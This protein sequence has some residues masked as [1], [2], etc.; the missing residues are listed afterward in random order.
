M[1]EGWQEF[2][3]GNKIQFEQEYEVW[4]DELLTLLR[5]SQNKD[6]PIVGLPIGH[7]PDKAI[8][9][10][11]HEVSS[12]QSVSWSYFN[13]SG[14]IVEECE[15]DNQ[16]SEE[17]NVDQNTTLRDGSANFWPL[18][19]SQRRHTRTTATDKLWEWES[20]KDMSLHGLIKTCQ[21]GES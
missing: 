8:F 21:A 7:I 9:I 17:D 20:N 16:R 13:A 15:T 6:I 1:C 14:S 10:S 19:N 2:E 5:L 11:T 18:L 4:R 3:T 12:K